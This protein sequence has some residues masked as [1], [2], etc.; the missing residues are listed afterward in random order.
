MTRDAGGEV[1]WDSER[2]YYCTRCL[3]TFGREHREVKDIASCPKCGAKVSEGVPRPLTLP[4]RK[5]EA[6]R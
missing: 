5:M 6:Y 4:E 2:G 3:S 1:M